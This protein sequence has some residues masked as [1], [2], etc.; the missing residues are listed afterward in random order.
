[1]R[2]CLGALPPK[3]QRRYN[4]E[5][6]QFLRKDL[7]QHLKNECP[8]R[9]DECQ[10]CGEKGTYAEIQE[11]DKTCEEKKIPCPNCKELKP[12]KDQHEHINRECPLAVVPCKFQSVGCEKK[13][14]RKEMATHEQDL[15]LHFC[16]ALDAVLKLTQENATFKSKDE[17][18][19]FASV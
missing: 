1:M 2:L 6:K 10:H 7:E 15:S 8:N 12:R 13:L 3:V 9:P 19:T 11:H 4:N 18:M 17:G 16:M 5:I 14:V